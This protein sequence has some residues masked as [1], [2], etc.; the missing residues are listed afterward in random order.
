MPKPCLLLLLA[1]LL[2][3][4][5]E[6][7]RQDTP[8]TPEEM[9]EQARHL[10][11]PNAEHDA[12]DTE[13]A[14]RWLTRAA[15]EGYLP[16]QV[17]LAG[18]YLNGGKNGLPPDHAAA[19]RWF[20]A[21]AAQGHTASHVFLGQLCY[22]GRGTPRDEA[23]ALSH[24]RRAAEAGLAEAQYRL[25]RVLAQHPD[26]RREGIEWLTKAAREGQRGGVPQAATALGNLYY[27]GAPD[28]TADRA[29]A[30]RWYAMG[31][32]AGDPLAQWVYAELLLAGEEG[33]PRNEEQAMSYLRLSAG[34]DCPQAM[35]RLIEC[36]RRGERAAEQENEAA[37]WEKRLQQLRRR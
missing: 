3:S 36:L 4:C 13:G 16:A 25:G 26:Q 23:A 20:C 18:I 35:E 33:V 12:S 10:L 5:G 34:Q 17:D 1:L 9:Y 29:Q 27:R 8:R 28:L 30:V 31:A 24:W 21:A 15:E 7:G 37:A 19:F 2:L 22:D 14:L 6:S 32:S 11:K